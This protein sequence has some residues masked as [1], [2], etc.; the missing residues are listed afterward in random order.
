MVSSSVSILDTDT[1]EVGGS[2]PPVPTIFLLLSDAYISAKN[3][4]NYQI[5]SNRI[6]LQAFCRHFFS[7]EISSVYGKR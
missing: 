3:L 6:I 1:E 4:K 5:T 7:M 2:I